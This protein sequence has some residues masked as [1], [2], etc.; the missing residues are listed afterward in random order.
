MTVE[1]NRAVLVGIAGDYE[2]LAK[3]AE[4]IN[5]TRSRLAELN[6][7]W[8]Q[9]L[10]VAPPLEQNVA[11]ARESVCATRD[12][13]Q[14]Y[15]DMA[16][17]AARLAEDADPASRQAWLCLAELWARLAETLECQARQASQAKPRVYR[18]AAHQS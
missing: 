15:R 5:E 13:V 10:V 3:S 18:Q 11:P 17:D 4:L 2:R 7:R 9:S 12:K 16:S 6:E 1:E 8:P 14:A